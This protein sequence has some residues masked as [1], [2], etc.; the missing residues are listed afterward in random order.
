[1]ASRI[2]P[3][4]GS[5]RRAGG[6]A[7]RA[8]SGA[9]TDANSPA[10]PMP[11][12]DT[13]RSARPRSRAARAAAWWF[14]GAA[15]SSRAQASYPARVPSA[16]Y[17]RTSRRAFSRIAA[18]SHAARSPK[19][20]EQP[21]GVGECLGLDRPPEHQRHVRVVAVEAAA[22]QTLDDRQ[23][24]AAAQAARRRGE[25]TADDHARLGGRQLHEARGQQGRDLS[26]VTQQP[27]RPGAD[28]L[29]RVRK[30]TRRPARRQ[31][32]R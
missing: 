20:A 6:R 17:R 28:V 7:L 21:L 25:L 30:Q 29:A 13:A 27:H 8:F 18:S 10:I 24:V 9:A 22:K 11:P 1:M 26:V 31:S 19:N 15:A 3:A 23:A 5:K 32:H 16:A 12:G 14:A 2:A 4:S